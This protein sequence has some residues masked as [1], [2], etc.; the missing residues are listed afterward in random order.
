MIPN[1]FHFVFGLERQTQPFHLVHYL[2]LA[3]CLEVNAPQAVYFYYHHEPYGRYWDLIRE[4]IIPV[5]IPPVPFINHYPYRDGNIA[6]YKYA[7]ASDFVRLEK[8]LAHGGI[9]ADMDTLF[10]NP[11][12]AALYDS[13][14]V[15]G[16]EDNIYDRRAR[17]MRP[18]LCNAF[19]MAERN[20]AFGTLWQDQLQ[21]AFDGSWSNHSTLLPNALAAQHPDLVHIEP[22]RTFYKHMWTP[23]GLHTLLQG[24]DTD[25]TGVVSFHLWAHLW[26]S[27]RR[28]DFSGF[29]GAKITEEHV[30]RVDTTYNV[31]ARKFLPPPETRSFFQI[32][33]ANLKRRL[34][35]VRALT[36]K[37]ERRA[38]ADTPD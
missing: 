21:G 12:P 25:N 9:Y 7:H 28:R 15:I 24:L 8:L 6:R 34:E 11:L 14:F 5:Q 35:R 19:L 33:S 38:S 31:V 16:R 1:R 23:A 18:S 17:Q 36:P 37:V 27:R 2:C 29:Y 3:S 32:Q 26:W 20:A 22:A 30:R 10:V 13:F 4:R